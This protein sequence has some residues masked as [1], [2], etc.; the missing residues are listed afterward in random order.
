[1][2]FLL[3]GKLCLLWA[4]VGGCVV[5]RGRHTV[6]QIYPKLVTIYPVQ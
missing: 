6:D 2:P 3:R 1:V 4:A 5:H